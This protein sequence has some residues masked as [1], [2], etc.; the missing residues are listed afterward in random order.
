[1]YANIYSSSSC[2]HDGCSSSFLKL[3]PELSVPLAQIFNMSLRQH[4]VPKS[5]K[6]ANVIP[7]YNVLFTV[8]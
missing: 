1:M 2:G 7:I 6:L 8:R 3:F 5:W 4:C